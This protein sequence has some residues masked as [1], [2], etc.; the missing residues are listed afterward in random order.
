MQRYR[1][2]RNVR[3]C[4]DENRPREARSV[5][6]GRGLHGHRGRAACLWR[7]V[8]A[9]LRGRPGARP[10]N[11]RGVLSYEEGLRLSAGCEDRTNE[12]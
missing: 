8:R 10:K 2:K 7:P 6:Q 11:V 1:D 4:S 12:V 5:F 9:F 3:R